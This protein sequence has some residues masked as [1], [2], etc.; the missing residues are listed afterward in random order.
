M[1]SPLVYKTWIFFSCYS[2]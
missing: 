2:L 1:K